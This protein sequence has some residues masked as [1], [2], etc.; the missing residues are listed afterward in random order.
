MLKQEWFRHF[1]GKCLPPVRAERL[2]S[3]T[4]QR[5]ADVIKWSM[6]GFGNTVLGKRV[7]VSGTLTFVWV[8]TGRLN[9]RGN[10]NQLT[11]CANHQRQ[12]HPGDIT[13]VDNTKDELNINIA[14]ENLKIKKKNFRFN[15]AFLS[16]SPQLPVFQLR[17]TMPG[18]TVQ[19]VIHNLFAII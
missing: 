13:T 16:R 6:A 12:F 1:W 5:L 2:S 18:A 10:L 17:T 9:R 14:G 11:V 8:R 4:S 7:S 15:R 3:N 19:C